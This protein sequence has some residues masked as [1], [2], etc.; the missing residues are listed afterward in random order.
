[1]RPPQTEIPGEPDM[2]RMHDAGRWAVGLCVLLLSG[3]AAFAQSPEGETVSDVIAR[4][5]RATAAEQVI[6]A[7][8]TRKDRPYKQTTVNED[9][10]VLYKTHLYPHVT[11]Y[12]Q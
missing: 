9:V 3:A 6:N 7:I 5:N 10:A 2:A 1:M 4:G 11:P 8:Q 12:Y